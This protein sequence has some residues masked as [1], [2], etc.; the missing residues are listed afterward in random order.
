MLDPVKAER[1]RWKHRLDKPWTKER[2]TADRL[3]RAART[4]AAKHG[5]IRA[6]RALAYRAVDHDIKAL[7]SECAARGQQ[8]K[9]SPVE[10]NT[11][12]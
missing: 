8:M 7:E 3:R 6:A 12:G 5:D 11:E 9:T 4:M 1:L 10:G 2:K